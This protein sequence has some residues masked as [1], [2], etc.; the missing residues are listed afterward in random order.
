MLADGIAVGNTTWWDGTQ[1]VVDNNN[2]FNAG[3]NVGVGTATPTA[4]LQ[5]IGTFAA[6][7]AANAATGTNAIA[8]GYQTN[9]SGS[10][11]TAMGYQTVASGNTSTAM[12]TNTTSSGDGSVAIGAYSNA[13]GEYA[14]A[15]GYDNTASGNY[16]TAFDQNSITSGNFSTAFGQFTTASGVTSTALGY[17]TTASGVFSTTMGKNTVAP[18]YAETALGL[19]NTTYTPASTM[20]W[21]STD[22][23]FVIGN[24]GP[25][26]ASNALTILKNGNMGIG[27]D[28][29]TA[30]LQVKDG[31]VYV[32]T[33]GSGVIM[34]SPDGGCWKL[35]VDNTGV[36]SATSVTCP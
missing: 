13:V 6:G 9:A 7:D 34:K 3:A 5:V 11:S 25:G 22:R 21:V 8:L 19:Y 29:P 23:L 17:A 27:N 16:S 26:S 1:W 31:D 24:G 4:N 12:G 28:T 33:I 14:I 2:I 30:K 15:I 35:T 18:S 20:S 32:E 36:V 10:V